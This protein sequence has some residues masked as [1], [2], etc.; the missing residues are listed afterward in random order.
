MNP[1]KKMIDHCEDVS[2]SRAQA[3][4]V[5]IASPIVCA[6]AFA[7][8]VFI[9]AGCVSLPQNQDEAQARIIA[10]ERAVHAGYGLYILIMDEAPDPELKAEFHK[11][12]MR[13]RETALALEA[14]IFALDAA[15]V[16]VHRWIDK[17]AEATTPEVIR[18]I[19][20]T[21]ESRVFGVP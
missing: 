13:A 9:L 20:D 8:L 4:A 14:F 7:V 3:R 21:G 17:Y 5:V 19:S 11:W 15:G 2:D 1:V 18:A 12:V 16:D 6:V 10:A